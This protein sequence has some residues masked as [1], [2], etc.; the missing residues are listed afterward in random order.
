MVAVIIVPALINFEA[1]YRRNSL[2]CMGLWLAEVKFDVI[3][4]QYTRHH[5]KNN[6][7]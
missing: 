1:R 4:I 3:L 6:T 5:R 2:F 7:K